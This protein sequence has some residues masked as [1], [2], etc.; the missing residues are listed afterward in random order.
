MSTDWAHPFRED[1]QEWSQGNYL[2]SDHL[3]QC[4]GDCQ[5]GAERWSLHQMTCS[6]FLLS[7]FILKVLFVPVIGESLYDFSK[8]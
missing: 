2:G 3:M 5:F 6:P 4:F 1:Y 7:W 8:I